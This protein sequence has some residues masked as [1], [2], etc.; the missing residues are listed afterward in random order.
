ME[1][2]LHFLKICGILLLSKETLR[3]EVYSSEVDEMNLIFN[4][5]KGKHCQK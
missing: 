5:V 2:L 1:K 3:K 4:I